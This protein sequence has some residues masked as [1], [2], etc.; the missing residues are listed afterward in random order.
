MIDKIK[1]AIEVETLKRIGMELWN[2]Y[3]SVKLID[4]HRI[5][6]KIQELNSFLGNF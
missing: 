5:K 1:Q 3:N 4:T 6:D 2:L